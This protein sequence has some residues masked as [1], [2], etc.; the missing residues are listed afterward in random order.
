MTM[1]HQDDEAVA[2]PIG[3]GIEEIHMDPAY[4]TSLTPSG[5]TAV[6]ATGRL[7]FYAATDLRR[8]LQGLIEAGA[9]RVVVDLSGVTSID[10]SGVGALIAGLKW[11]RSAGGD[12]RL[13]AP[14]ASVAGIL[15]MMNLATVLVAYGS[16][17][18]AF[19]V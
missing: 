15:G 19:P 1:K 4:G 16:T 5:A 12:L 2:L 7:D 6:A 14:P 9:N 18:D 10:S 8:Q 13:A 17:E 11:A 3:E